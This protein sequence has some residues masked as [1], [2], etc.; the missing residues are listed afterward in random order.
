MLG[1]GTNVMK[2]FTSVIYKWINIRLSVCPESAKAN[3][4]EP[5]T[6]FGRVFNSNLGCIATPGSK[7]MV[8]MQPLLKL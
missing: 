6:G 7:C 8:C 3:G 2:L 5:K 1:P 4:R